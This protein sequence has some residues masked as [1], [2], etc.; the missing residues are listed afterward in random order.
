MVE[1]LKPWR[2]DR[3]DGEHKDFFTLSHVL[4]KISHLRLFCITQLGG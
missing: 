4:R 2:C 1:R 3:K